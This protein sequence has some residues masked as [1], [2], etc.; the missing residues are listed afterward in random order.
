MALIYTE[1][2]LE[3]FL[4][5][6]AL[7]GGCHDSPRPGYWSRELSGVCLRRNFKS[8]GMHLVPPPLTCWFRWFR[9]DGVWVCIQQRFWQIE[10][11]QPPCPRFPL[12]NFMV[13][14]TCFS[15][16]NCMK[17]FIAI[18]F[19]NIYWC[20]FETTF[21]CPSSHWGPNKMADIF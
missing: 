16:L 11:C 12:W 15:Q 4:V 10:Y 6:Q 17:K 5:T 2:N 18:W 19:G 7:G 3:N 9:T 14:A 1:F 20:H 13:I 21:S 8:R